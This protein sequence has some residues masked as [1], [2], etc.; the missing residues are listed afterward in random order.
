MHGRLA[1]PLALVAMMLASLWAGGLA[2]GQE[3]GDPVLVGAGDIASCRSTGDEDTAALLGASTA[4]SLPSA[5]TPTNPGRAPSS[6][7][8][9][10]PPGASSRRA[11]S[12]AWATANT[13]RSAPQATSTTSARPPATRRRAT[14]P[15]IWDR[16]T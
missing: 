6:P 9:T 1:A 5:T 14:T 7:D 2:V 13:R 10:T 12:P 16:G 11:P 8:V 4:R 3:G 15:T